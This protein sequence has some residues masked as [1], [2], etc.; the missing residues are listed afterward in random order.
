MPDL[1]SIIIPETEEISWQPTQ[2][3]KLGP[4]LLYGGADNAKWYGNN[5][6]AL[7]RV[8][9]SRQADKT[10]SLDVPGT[11]HMKHYVPYQYTIMGWGTVINGATDLYR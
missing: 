9:K 6:A 5:Y 8:G 1:N 7:S 4:T 2:V 10:P 3:I 11:G